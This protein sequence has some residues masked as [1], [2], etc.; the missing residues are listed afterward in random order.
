MGSER[1]RTSTHLAHD[2]RLLASQPDDVD[3]LARAFA[4]PPV[5]S[6]VASEPAAAETAAGGASP[7]TLISALGSA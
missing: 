3:L 1:Q 7:F 4:G 6:I 2:R 5:M